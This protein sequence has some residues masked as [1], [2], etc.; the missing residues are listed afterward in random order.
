[1]GPR[2]AFLISF[3][4]ALLCLVM[5]SV[6][7]RISSH[8]LK[9]VDCAKRTL[10]QTHRRVFALKGNNNARYRMILKG[11]LGNRDDKGILSA[12]TATNSMLFANIAV[13]LATSAMPH[14]QNAMMK[15]DHRIARGETYR[16]ATALFA[17][18]GL[19]HL[20]M[21]CLSLRNIGPQVR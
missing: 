3:Y 19:T 20:A 6:S 21:N 16:M 12:V 10:D 7:F 8:S 15:M 5:G 11:K 18:G 2:I 1:M 13:F 17:H 14:L 4:V 9:F